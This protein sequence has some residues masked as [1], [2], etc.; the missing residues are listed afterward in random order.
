MVRCSRYLPWCQDDRPEDSRISPLQPSGKT[1]QRFGKLPIVLG[2]PVIVNQ[3]FDVEGRL[4]NGSFGYLR[5]YRFQTDEDGTRILTS[6][7]VEV[8]DLTCE[9]LPH[10]PPKHVAVISDTVEM[11]S[12]VHPVSGRSCTMKRS[13]VPLAP[14]FAMTAH[15]AQG[16]T[17]PHVI[18]DLASCRGT[19]SPYV[20]VSRCPHLN[21]LMILRP[22]PISKIS[23]H[24]SQES[25]DEFSRLDALRLD[26]IA[27][28][29]TQSEREN[30]KIHSTLDGS[31]TA[32][33]EQLF[34][35]GGSHD[36]SQVGDLVGQLQHDDGAYVN[37]N[38]ITT[39]NT[40]F[41]SPGIQTSSSLWRTYPP[42]Y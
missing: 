36:P 42:P 2:M 6:C 21:G 8:P 9:P 38:V 3:D 17:L 19:E 22:F 29:G 20:M 23:C 12:I 35:N 40:S 13:Q 18:V 33:I 30:A 5:D 37:G 24:R 7:I 15:K 27:T 16:L 4:V 34:L 25:R 32:A 39:D 1:G 26:T 14:G 10:L 41:V 28:H 31:R 11:R